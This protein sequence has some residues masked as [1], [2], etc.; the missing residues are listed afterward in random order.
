MSITDESTD[1]YFVFPPQSHLF[2]GVFGHVPLEFGDVAGDFLSI[3]VQIFG[4]LVLL[5]FKDVGEVG[6][7]FP[8]DAFRERVQ[9]RQV[10]GKTHQ[11]VQSTDLRGWVGVGGEC[12]GEC[13]GAY[14]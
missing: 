14:V 10:I 12:G 3:G 7:D 5:V 2:D 4:Q 8:R 1:Q 11:H 6:G 13:G 9:L